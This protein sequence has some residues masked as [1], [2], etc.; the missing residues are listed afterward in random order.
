ARSYCYASPALGVNARF[1]GRHRIGRMPQILQ[2]QAGQARPVACLAPDIAE[3]GTGEGG[4]LRA[5]EDQPLIRQVS[6][7]IKPSSAAAAMV[8]GSNRYAFAT[9][10]GPNC[11]EAMGPA[12]RHSL[13]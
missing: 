7:R 6:R 8:A 1:C 12:V 3:I 9:V 11:G 2:V 10:I 5:D 4:P 13:Y